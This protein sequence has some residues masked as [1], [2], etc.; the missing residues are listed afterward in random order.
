[1]RKLFVALLAM[2]ALAVPGSAIASP[3][4]STQEFEATLSGAE[5]VPPVATAATGEAQFHLGPGN[6]VTYE[7][8]FE[9]IQGVFAAHIHAPAPRGT[10]A[11]VRQF[12]CGGAGTPPC[13]DH[14]VSGSF[15]VT[16]LLL[17]QMR[18]GLAYVNAH[19]PSHPAGE[20]RGQ[21]VV[22]D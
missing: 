11:S 10:N 16:T 15:V 12:L 3:E 5:E 8:S 7:L 21:I 1:M 9:N 22:D 17:E 14:E 13:N 2:A 4:E 6:V 20:I 18:N 19:T